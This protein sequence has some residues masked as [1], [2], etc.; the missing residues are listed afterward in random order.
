MIQRTL[1]SRRLQSTLGTPL[2]AVALRQ[3]VDAAFTA[4]VLGPAPDE[5]GAH[6][7]ID[8]RECFLGSTY[9]RVRARRRFLAQYQAHALLCT[10]LN[11]E[12]PAGREVTGEAW[13][14]SPA[15]KTGW[16]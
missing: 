11:V 6:R 2:R 7:V 14:N 10:D 16:R 12:N 3:E 1:H 15:S 9:L 4:G 13:E 5:A 8:V